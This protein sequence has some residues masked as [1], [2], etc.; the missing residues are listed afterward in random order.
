M[1]VQN[2]QRKYFLRDELMKRIFSLVVFLLTLN[3]LFSCSKA[4]DSD[5]PQARQ[6]EFIGRTM[7]TTYNVKVIAPEAARG[8]SKAIVEEEVQA[9]IDALLVEVNQQMSTYIPNSEL[10]QFNKAPADVDFAVSPELAKV[11]KEGIRLGE[12]T[13]GKLDITVGPLVNLWGFGPDKKPV[14]AP[15]DVQISDAK[16]RIGFD[17]LSVTDKGLRKSQENLYVDLSTIAKGY[18]VD[19]VADYLEQQGW[20]NYL[21]EIGGEMRSSGQKVGD[22][23]WRV[24]VEKPIAGERSVQVIFAPGDNA[25]AT[26]GDYRNY[27]EQDGVRFSHIIDT[28]TGK[29]ITHK[30]VSVTVLHESSMTADGLSTALMTFGT[31]AAIQ[32]AEQNNLAVYMLTKTADGFSTYTSKPFEKHIR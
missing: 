25:I 31:D 23:E 21:V 7:G 19:A 15:S 28:A 32:F 3:L 10:S 5:T 6:Y 9:D 24:A 20:H 14:K 26:S 2:S 27:F 17:K 1:L 30:L 13:R 22:K 4:I 29:P 16:A 11:V 8:D 18:G 12:L